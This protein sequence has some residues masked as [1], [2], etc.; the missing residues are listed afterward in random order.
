MEMWSHTQW[1]APSDGLLAY[2]GPGAGFAVAG[3]FLTVFLAIVSA[4]LMILLWP[5]R[6]MLRALFQKRPP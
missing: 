6:K 1:L 2:I 3:S 5:A 4:L